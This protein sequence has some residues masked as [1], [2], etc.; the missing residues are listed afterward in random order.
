MWN[1]LRNLLFFIY[2]NL[3]SSKYWI[4]NLSLMPHPEGGYYKEVYRSDKSFQPK[5]FTGHRNY[6]TSIHF[7]LEK[8]ELRGEGTFEKLM[9]ENT[10]F[11]ANVNKM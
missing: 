4:E 1:H 6:M 10:N 5:D 11:R 3:K 2:E 7:L 9:K 8:G